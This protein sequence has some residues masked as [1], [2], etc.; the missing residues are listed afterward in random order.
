MDRI[1]FLAGSGK[2]ICDLEH[3]RLSIRNVARFHFERLGGSRN[4]VTKTAIAGKDGS[5]GR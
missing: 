1:P 5:V 2:G 4:G 3:F